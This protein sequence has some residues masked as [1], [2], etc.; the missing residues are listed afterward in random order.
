MPIYDEEHLPK[1]VLKVNGIY[2][3]LF[4]IDPELDYLRQEILNTEKEIYVA[5]TDGLIDRWE[6]DFGLEYDASLTLEQ[7]RQRVA[8]KLARK[9]TLN[10]TNLKLLIK[11]NTKNVQFYI[12]NH[13]DEYMFRVI[14]Q[15]MENADYSKLEKEIRKAKPAYIIFNLN[16]T[17]YFRRCG[18]FNCGTEPL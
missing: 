6:R 5:T 12:S 11:N 3:I 2:D 14:L 4:A 10:W 13:S 7:R 18:T 9:K 8:N 16:V 17:D 15:L 1:H